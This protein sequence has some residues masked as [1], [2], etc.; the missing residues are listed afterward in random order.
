[1]S[2]PVLLVAGLDPVL[3]DSLA[4]GLVVDVPGLVVVRHDVAP[5]DDTLHRHV[6]DARGPLESQTLPLDDDC[7]ACALHDDLVPTLRRVACRRPPAVVVTLPVAAEPL[8]ALRALAV[9]G[10]P[11]AVAAVVV[12]AA[13]ATVE[14][15]LLGDALLDE[16]GLAVSPADRR[17]VGEVLAHQLD[18]ADAVLLDADPSGRPTARVRR[19][20]EH[21]TA[22][23]T[24]VAGLHSAPVAALLGRR[25]DT[26]DPRGDLSRCVPS[27]RADGD[28][29]W[30][31]DLGSWRPFHPGRLLDSLEVL[32]G[33]P[34]R[35][36]GR[37]WLPTRPGR[38]FGWDGA[39]G[40]LGVGPLPPTARIGG[41]LSTRL[42]VTGTDGG[43]D[44][45]R[46]AFDAALA[47]DAEL[48]RGLDRWA[49]LD[50]GLDPWLGPARIG[51]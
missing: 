12:V 16:A 51:A 8:P 6:L 34:L 30:T 47:T 5:G 50:D 20:L 3:R 9:A 1:M 42:V 24:D 11:L 38:L 7:L 15:D 33:G 18:L 27:G 14:V 23:G 40:Q 13:A 4:A 49:G 44:A 35:G 19:L 28:G 10:P 37:F 25:R 32:G 36:R 43:P 41:P 45:L 22:P 31:V 46:A 48:A 17:A 39:G 29:V 21:V 2:V 26:D